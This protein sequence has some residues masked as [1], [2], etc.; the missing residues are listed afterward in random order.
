VKNNAKKGVDG[1]KMSREGKILFWKGGGFSFSNQ[2]IDRS[3][4]ID[5]FNLF[6]V[7]GATICFYLLKKTWENK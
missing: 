1:I 2:N 7:Q 5:I 3:E 6:L 4:Y